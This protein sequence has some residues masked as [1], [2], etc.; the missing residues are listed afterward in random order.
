MKSL[1]SKVLFRGMSA[2]EIRLFL[3]RANPYYVRLYGGRS[4]RIEK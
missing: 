3:D 2:E 4:V 1:Q